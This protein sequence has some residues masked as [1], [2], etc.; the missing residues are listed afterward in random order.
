MKFENDGRN[1]WIY[2]GSTRLSPL[3]E[4]QTRQKTRKTARRTTSAPIYV[5]RYNT[6]ADI[7]VL[8]LFEACVN[9]IRVKMEKLACGGRSQ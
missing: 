9:Q 7:F 2:R 8:Q 4:K 3:Y 1:E 5:S 6:I